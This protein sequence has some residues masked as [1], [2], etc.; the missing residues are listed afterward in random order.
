MKEMRLTGVCRRM[1]L[2]LAFCAGMTGLFFSYIP[3]ELIRGFLFAFCGTASITT[4]FWAF[5]QRR[6][7]S[8]FS[9][10]ICETVDILME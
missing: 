9:N 10:D 2:G 5:W 6:Q 8:D 4:V 7:L 3:Q 1:L